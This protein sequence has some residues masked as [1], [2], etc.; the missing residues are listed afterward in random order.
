MPKK[1]FNYIFVDESGDP[2]KPYK[3]D[4]FGNRTP[5]G[6]SLYYILSAVC[7]EKSYQK[8]FINKDFLV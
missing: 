2:G 4:N 5:T 1:S 6:A 7:F 8:E 3:I